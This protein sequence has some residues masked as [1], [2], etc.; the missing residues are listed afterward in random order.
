MVLC[1]YPILMNNFVPWSY[2][3]H[4]EFWNLHPTIRE[5]NSSKSNHLPDWDLYF[6]KLCH[7]EYLSYQMMNTH[8][9]LKAAFEKCAIDHLNNREIQRRIYRQGLSFTEFSNGLE[10]ILQPVYQSAKN[11]GFDHWVYLEKDSSL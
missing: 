5:I 11:C 6:S 1:N 3:A 2:V 4:D 10:E 7:L 8:E 9:V